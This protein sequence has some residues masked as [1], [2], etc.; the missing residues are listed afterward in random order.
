MGQV[1]RLA[2][3]L[4]CP[5][6]EL[7]DDRR[8]KRLAEMTFVQARAE[9]PVWWT[10]HP[11]RSGLVVAWAGGPKAIA[12]GK[13]PR[14]LP[15]R[16]IASLSDVFRVDRRTVQR[17]VV[18]TMHHDWSRDP[19]SRGAYSYVL[20]GGTDAAA[21]LARPVRGT[22]FFAGEATDPE[23]RTGTVHGAIATGRRAAAQAV[24][25]LSS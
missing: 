5:L 9:L 12:L 15:S 11:V 7:M 4:D 21:A 8:Q 2:V 18:R 25:A 3:L 1:Q 13:S 10:S 6:V 16:V 17:N 14:T 22:L 19:F 20:V 23:G 24:R